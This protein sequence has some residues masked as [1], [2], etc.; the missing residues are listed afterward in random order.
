[1]SRKQQTFIVNIFQLTNGEKKH[2]MK[3]VTP[4]TYTLEKRF[5]ATATLE[6]LCVVTFQTE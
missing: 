5:Y 2:S 4:I 1:M 6:G 3:Q